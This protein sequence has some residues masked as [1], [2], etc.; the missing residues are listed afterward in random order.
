MNVRQDIYVTIL[1]NAGKTLIYHA[2][3]EIDF[4]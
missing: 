2:A 1:H 4:V 3:I